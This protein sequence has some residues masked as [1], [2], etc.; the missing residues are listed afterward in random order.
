M[1]KKKLY[2]DI[3]WKEIPSYEVT[4][5]FKLTEE[6]KRKLKSLKK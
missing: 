3:R 1:S 5:E 6:Q 2:S 4:G